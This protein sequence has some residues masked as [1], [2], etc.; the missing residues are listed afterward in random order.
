M[1]ALCAEAL[2]RTTNPG[3]DIDRRCDRVGVDMRRRQETEAENPES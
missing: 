2:A 1:A 3:R